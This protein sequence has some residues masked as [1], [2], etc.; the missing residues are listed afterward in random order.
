MSNGERAAEM[1]FKKYH[2]IYEPQK[3]FNDC[4]DKYTL[5]FD[6]YLP[7]YNLIVEIMGEQH[8]HPI[9]YFGGQE[10][11]EIQV[12]HDK[13]KRD[14]LK[15]NNIHCLDIWY[16]EFDQMESIILNKIQEI[17]NK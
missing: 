16:Y 3:R 14:Y 9:D 10:K 15:Q 11:F 5:P 1:I 17:I 7:E 13:M 12:R 4:F 6:F 8:E 2:Y